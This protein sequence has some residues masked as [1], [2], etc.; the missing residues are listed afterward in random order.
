MGGWV[1]PRILNALKS[2]VPQ[3]ACQGLGVGSGMPAE[4]LLAVLLQ[5]LHRK[6]D[7][8][9]KAG[10]VPEDVTLRTFFFF[11]HKRTCSCG[12]GGAR[13]REEIR[14][15]S[16]GPVPEPKEQGWPVAGHVHVQGQEGAASLPLASCRTQE[17]LGAGTVGGGQVRGQPWP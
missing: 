4:N 17:R 1:F 8:T 10:P 3:F 2:Q 16:S 13:L 7:L 5:T 15:A 14:F 11:V 12:C 9:S 6:L